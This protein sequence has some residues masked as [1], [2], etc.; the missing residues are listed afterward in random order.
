MLLEFRVKNY[1]TYKKEAVFSMIASNYDKKELE[2]E[3]VFW[4][5]KF[6]LRVLKSAAIYGA[7]A[8]GKSKF[9][10]ALGF[11]KWFVLNSFQSLKVVDPIPVQNF[12]LSN[13]TVRQPSAFELVFFQDGSIYRYGFEVNPEKVEKEWLFRRE[14][15]KE[16]KI[17][18][19]NGA[20]I[21]GHPDHFKISKNE[22][23]KP[24]IRSNCLLLSS[25]AQANDKEIEK[26]MSWFKRLA[27]FSGLDSS[28][29]EKMTVYKSWDPKIKERILALLVAADTGIVN[30]NVEMSPHFQLTDPKTGWGVIDFDKL[31]NPLAH[32]DGVKTTHLKYNE[33][34]GMTEEVEFSMVKDESGGTR[35]FFALAYPILEALTEG[36]T[37]VVDELDS[38]L[39]PNLA[40]KIISLFNS[41]DN[42]NGAQLIFNT[43]NT[44]ILNSN[45]MRRDQVWF[46]EKDIYGA[47]KL[48]SLAD[49][50]VRKNDKFEKEYLD[51][52][53]GAVPYLVELE[54]LMTLRDVQ[55]R[56]S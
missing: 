24:F 30:Y 21:I 6:D 46:V 52:R 10:E 26:I 23:F 11:V 54:N 18:E 44:N 3:N 36:N 42:K 51:G 53:Y 56:F 49:I 43:H 29:P 47:A 19:R 34:T 20:E 48:Y 5:E 15:R 38:N 8:S 31:K 7:N 17:F 27:M 12:S 14:K 37:L 32:I 22:F 1:R 4:E 41:A 13:I 40:E 35:K 9:M 50:Q 28:V 25:A 16:V 55:R 2:T 45:L 33:E 39:H